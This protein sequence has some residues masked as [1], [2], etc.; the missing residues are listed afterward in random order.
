MRSLAWLAVV[1]IGCTTP[2]GVNP[3]DAL[4]ALD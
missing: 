1:F 2:T 3:L 4:G